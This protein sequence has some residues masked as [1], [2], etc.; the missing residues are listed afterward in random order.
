MPRIVILEKTDYCPPSEMRFIVTTR[1]D[2]VL[3]TKTVPF[4]WSTDLQESVLF[5]SR[6]EADRFVLGHWQG[7]SHRYPVVPVRL[8]G[9]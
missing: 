5:E 9:E 4:Q 2:R 6:Q 1:D 8:K 7:F 3:S